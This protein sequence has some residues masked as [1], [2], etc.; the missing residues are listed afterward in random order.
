MNPSIDTESTTTDSPKTFVLL[1]LIIIKGGHELGL[2]RDVSFPTFVSS[3]RTNKVTY[4]NWK[5]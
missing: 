4:V 2:G 3:R 5:L 1:N